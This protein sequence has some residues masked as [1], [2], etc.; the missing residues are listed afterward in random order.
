MKTTEKP[1]GNSGKAMKGICIALLLSVTCIWGYGI[2]ATDDALAGNM[3][4]FTMLA[5]RFLLAAVILFVLRLCLFKTRQYA[6]FNKKEVA[7]GLLVGAVN[8]F[9]FFFQSIGLLYTNTAKSGMLTGGYV[10]IVPVLYCIFR[11]KFQWKPLFNALLFLAGMFFL[12]DLRHSGG[13]FNRGD[14]FTLIAAWFFAAQIMLVD[15]KAKGINVF[16][17]SAM[18]MLAMGLLGLLGALIFERNSFASVNWGVCLPSVLYLGALSSAYAYIIQ[19]FAQ[20]RIS[21]SLAAILLSLESLASVLFSLMFGRVEWTSSLAV[22][23]IVMIAASVAAA[24]EDSDKRE[25]S[26][27]EK[28]Q[29]PEGST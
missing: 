10:I 20:S 4:A 26:G 19:T 9:G 11:K 23:S 5:G 17:F 22:G 14:A 8:F 13:N 3:G 7:A 24:L 15:K 21:P 12:F 27:A 6:P 29:E 25:E 18:Q 28:P 2:I 16:N 1:F